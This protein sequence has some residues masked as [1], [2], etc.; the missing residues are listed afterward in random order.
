MDKQSERATEQNGQRSS[1]VLTMAINKL[2][3]LANT[4]YKDI[5]NSALLK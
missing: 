5:L 2:P 1:H 3:L 4:C